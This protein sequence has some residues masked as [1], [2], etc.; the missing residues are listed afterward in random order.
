MEKDEK[1]V[2]E[3]LAEDDSRRKFL[4]NALTAGGATALAT[5][6]GLEATAARAADAPLKVLFLITHSDEY[7]R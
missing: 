1:K 3:I 2:A 4:K 6:A 5:M 7:A